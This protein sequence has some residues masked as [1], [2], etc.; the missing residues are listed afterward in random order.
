MIFILLF[1]PRSIMSRDINMAPPMRGRP[2]LC[3]KK[4]VF[5]AR[6][7]CESHSEHD[8]EIFL[9]SAL[10]LCVNPLFGK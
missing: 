3:R 6:L 4:K 10:Y 5:S 2:S 9:K 1:L 8:L 7:A